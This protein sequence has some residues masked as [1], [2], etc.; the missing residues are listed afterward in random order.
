MP[1]PALD[2]PE[3]FCMLTND[4]F[5]RWT[6]AGW[7]HKIEQQLDKTG[8]SLE[9]DEERF[10]KNLLTEQNNFQDRLDG[11]NMV[12]AGFSAHTHTSK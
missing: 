3:Y 1:G 2:G 12:V 8:E 4:F 6:C 10:H 9:E 7:P 11:L 5:R